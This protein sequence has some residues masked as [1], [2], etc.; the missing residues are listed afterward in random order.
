MVRIDMNRTHKIK[1]NTRLFPTPFSFVPPVNMNKDRGVLVDE[2]GTAELGI[3]LAAKDLC[4]SALVMI[5][6]LGSRVINTS[7]INNHIACRQLG[8]VASANKICQLCFFQDEEGGGILNRVR[9]LILVAPQRD[10]KKSVDDVAQ[11]V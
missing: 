1:T 7:N 9:I 10:D 2:S 4:E 11:G 3:E 8:R 5:I 6:A